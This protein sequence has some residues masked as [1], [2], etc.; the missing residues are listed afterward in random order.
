MSSKRYTQQSPALQASAMQ[1]MNWAGKQELTG[2]V[3]PQHQ[4]QQDTLVNAPLQV[5]VQ[6]NPMNTQMPQTNPC[7][8]QDAQTICVAVAAEQAVAVQDAQGLIVADVHEIAEPC[9]PQVAIEAF[10][11]LTTG[12]NLWHTQ[13][14]LLG[15]ELNIE[16]L[17]CLGCFGDD[18]DF[19]GTPEPGGTS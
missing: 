16:L 7:E 2:Q 17:P 1:P 8:M 11:G 10:A 3:V 4:C 12:L 13:G 15:T 5:N 18:I 9:M 6:G 19:P 14:I